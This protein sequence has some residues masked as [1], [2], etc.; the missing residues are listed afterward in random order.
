MPESS[1]TIKGKKG[2]RKK[3]KGLQKLA[4]SDAMS[5]VSGTS[6]GVSNKQGATMM[7]QEQKRLEL[8]KKRQAKEIEQMMAFEI[9]VFEQ[10]A[11]FVSKM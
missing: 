9:K 4:A 7:E 11:S 8:M 1:P 6:T 3:K 10:A 5:V 2:K